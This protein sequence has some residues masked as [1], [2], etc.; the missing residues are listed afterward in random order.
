MRIG[1]KTV[2][3]GREKQIDPPTDIQIKHINTRVNRRQIDQQ[4]DRLTERR[5]Q[6]DI[7]GQTASQTD[8]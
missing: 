3:T 8:T 1:R 5:R 6:T 7:D 4:I 2:L